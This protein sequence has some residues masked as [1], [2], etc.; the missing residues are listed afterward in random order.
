MAKRSQIEKPELSPLAKSVLESMT[1]PAPSKKKVAPRM[2]QE[3]AEPKSEEGPPSLV[4]SI[5]NVLNGG[6]EDSIER[7]AFEADPTQYN[8]Y[9][10]LYRAK[11]KLL[12]DTILKRIAIQ[13]D[14]VASITNAR[15]NQVSQFGR[16][17]PN[18]HEVGFIVEPKPGVMDRADSDQK[19]ELQK[20]MDD[21]QD[22]LQSCGDTHGWSQDDKLTFS[23]YLGMSTRNAVTVGRIATEIVRVV[24]AKSGQKR[25]HSFRPID[26]GTIYRAVPQKEAAQQVREQARH[27]LESLKNKKLEPEKFEQDEYTWVQ[28]IEG[29]PVQAF[30]SEE[31]LVHNFYPVTDIELD[32]YPLTPL[33]TI[34]NAVTT[35]INITQ[36]NKVY[37]QS[38]RAARGMLVIKSDDVD[39]GV[40]GR[41]RQQFNASINSVANAWRMPV[42]AVGGTDEITW[43]PID[44]GARDM[45]FQFLSDTN[46]RVILSAYQMSPEELPGYAHLS[47]GTNNQALSESNQEYKLEAHRDV[48][49]RPLIKGWEDFIN[50]RIFPLID[51]K[52]AEICVVKLI[53]LDAETAEKEAVRIQQDMA[54]HMTT[55]EILDTVEK[56]PIG[57]KWG[58]EFLLNPQWQAVVDKYIPVGDIM[59]HFFGVEGASKNPSLHYFR[60]SFWFQMQAFMQQQQQMQMQAQQAQQAAAQGQPPPGGDGGGEG[61]GGAPGG[62]G[63]QEGPPQ[64]AQQPPQGQ[65]P[66]QGGEGGALTRSL[67][68]AV[69][70]LS[71]SEAQ[72]PPGKKK[73][74][75]QHKEMMARFDTGWTKDLEEATKEILKVAGKYEPKPKA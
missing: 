22:R 5:L 42:F 6:K 20:R 15:A 43:S 40:V 26:A 36:H 63:G 68:Q 2:M 8:M 30:T 23:Q 51:P 16:V 46:A 59:E 55:D 28:V 32:G 47:R 56:D 38:G 4:K 49:I 24:D 48:G 41:I 64:D 67:D 11:V 39:E 33:D 29:R 31:C 72:L 69:M 66:D 61:G 7:L 21:A 17:R 57:K 74:L 70:L 45:E 75:A 37:F 60:D 1:A 53:G 14:L 35:H 50:A 71:K 54:V 12:P 19:K 25:F 65:P 10:A 34:I 9:A 58:G 18:R 13:D 73:I 44:S 62:G 3:Q 52:L 27:L